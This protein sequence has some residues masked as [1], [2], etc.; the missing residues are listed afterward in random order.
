MT[1]K[2]VKKL[3]VDKDMLLKDL[4]DKIPN[5]R[6]GYYTTKAG[7]IKAMRYGKTKSE[8]CERIT[9][10]SFVTSFLSENRNNIE[11]HHK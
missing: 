9:S 3:L 2:D 5:Q 10:D 4:N 7:L 6:G 1:Y 8:I 11:I